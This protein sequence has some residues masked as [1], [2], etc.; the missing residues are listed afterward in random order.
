[1]SRLE[2]KYLVSSNVIDELRSEITPFLNHDKYTLIRPNKE[3]TVRSIYLDTLSLSSYYEKLSGV[4]DRSKFRIRVYNEQLP[5]SYGFLEIKSKKCDFVFKDRTKIQLSD[6]INFLEGNNGKS[7]DG[8]TS[9][10]ENANNFLFHYKSK[11]LVPIVNI[12]YDREAFE[13]K[14]GSTLRVTFDKNLRSS[15]ATGINELYNNSKVKTSLDNFFVLEIKFHKVLPSWVPRIINKFHLRREAVSKY[16]ISVER[17]Q[18][19]DR[20][21]PQY[22]SLMEN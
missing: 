4:A 10:Q 9:I 5:N 14:L 21:Y 8:H 11:R 3:Y 17:H 20:F 1:M 12:I 19:N 16:T 2:Y 13:C 22:L 15:V 6:V 18:V 7:Q